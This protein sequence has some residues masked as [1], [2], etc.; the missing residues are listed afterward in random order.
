VPKVKGIFVF[1]SESES[2]SESE[3]DDE[4]E[5]ED[6]KSTEI[7]DGELSNQGVT[8]KYVFYNDCCESLVTPFPE[9]L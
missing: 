7:N 6:N 2:E 1:H 4:T 9:V 8:K 3:S 5:E